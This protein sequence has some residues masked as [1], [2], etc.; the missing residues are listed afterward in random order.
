MRMF[1]LAP[2]VPLISPAFAQTPDA[3][4]RSSVQEV[5]LDVVGFR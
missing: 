1:P 4:I 5:L 2:V 3:V